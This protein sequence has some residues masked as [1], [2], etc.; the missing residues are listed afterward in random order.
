MLLQPHVGEYWL[1][2]L[3]KV[4][5]HF[6]RF[7]GDTL[8]SNP[9]RSIRIRMTHSCYISSEGS[10][11]SKFQYL[12]SRSRVKR[13]GRCLFLTAQQHCTCSTKIKV[14]TPPLAAPV[15]WA[16][17][18]KTPITFPQMPSVTPTYH[19][20]YVADV[21]CTLL[22]YAARAITH[23]YTCDWEDGQV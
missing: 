6:Q 8:N 18:E 21:Y 1:L 17:G 14:H 5:V 11:S 10:S 22:L 9:D 3:S 2:G 23:F 7:L 20:Y 15:L 12:I 16:K 13:A 4:M 19:I